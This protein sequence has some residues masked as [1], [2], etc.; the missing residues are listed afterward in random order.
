LSEL[1]TDLIDVLI[2]TRQLLLLPANDFC[3][4]R[5]DGA[6]SAVR[7][8]DGYIHLLRE[9]QLPPRMDL[10]ILFVPTGSIQEVS[11]SSGWAHEF[12]P[13]S[14]QFDRAE[15]RAYGRPAAG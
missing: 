1:L 10:S 9:G 12:L 7:D 8:I 5:W 2:R 3:W 15:E 11:L 4:S 13:L 14:E 6:E